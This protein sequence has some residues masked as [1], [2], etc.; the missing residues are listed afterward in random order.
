MLCAAGASGPIP[1]VFGAR[2]F[3]PNG[4]SNPHLL[5]AKLASLTR[6]LGKIIIVL[7]SYKKEV[8]YRPGIVVGGKEG[9]GDRANGDT[10]F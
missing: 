3:K 9:K 4:G 1:L 10:G 5:L 2:R 8:V 7:G 6:G